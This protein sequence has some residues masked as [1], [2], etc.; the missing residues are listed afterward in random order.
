[1]PF[2]LQSDIPDRALPDALQRLLVQQT[3][4]LEAL[5]RYA[6]DTMD[7]I[8]ANGDMSPQEQTTRVDALAQEIAE[9]LTVLEEQHSQMQAQLEEFHRL[10]RQQ[11]NSIL[12]QASIIGSATWPPSDPRKMSGSI[13]V[14]VETRGRPR[15]P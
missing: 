15:H 11:G 14:E 5:L 1:M 8:Q 12:A 7:T 13:P 4:A 9:Q 2:G 3:E 10:L 6:Q